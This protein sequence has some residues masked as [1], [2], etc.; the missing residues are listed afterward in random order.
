MKTAEIHEL[1][2]DELAKVLAD[3]QRELLNLR[4]QNQLNQLENPARLRQVRRQ[5]ARL[6]TEA[7]S[8]KSA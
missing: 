7:N 6:L 3:S 2:I 5:I 1:T 4:I 8:R